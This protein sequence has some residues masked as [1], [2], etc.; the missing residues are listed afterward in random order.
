MHGLH[1]NGIESSHKEKGIHKA[2][3]AGF[4]G[5]HA[6]DIGLEDPRKSHQSKM[7]KKAV[8]AMAKLAIEAAR[9][10][11]MVAMESGN[12]GNGGR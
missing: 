10:A 7:S 4:C 3:A 11:A 12:G 2:K 8:R 9:V 1:V 6:R 5:P